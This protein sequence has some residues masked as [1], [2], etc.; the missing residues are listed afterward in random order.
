MRL[1]SLVLALAALSA[2]FAVDTRFWTFASKD[3]HDKATLNRLSLRSDGRITLAPASREL[4]DSGVSYLWAI[5]R[6]ADGTVYTG[7]G[8]P[9]AA[10]AR[11]FAV[12][13]GQTRVL[14]E[15]DGLQIQ[16]I[17]LDSAGRVYAATAPDGKIFRAGSNGKGELFYD[18][19]AKYI[20]SIAFDKS[21][22]LFVA[23]GDR[24]EIH[25]VTPQGQ[26]SVFFRTEEEHARSMVFDNAGNLIIGTEPSGLIMRV[27]PA[28]EGFVLHQA[29][30]REIT[31]L[32]VAPDGAIYAAAVGNKPNAP[33]APP[34]PAPAAAPAAAITVSA[35]GPGPASAPRA[36]APPPTLTPSSVSGGSEVIRIAADGFPTRVW[37]DTTE[38]VYAITFDKSGK[39]ILGSGNKGGIYR[40]DNDLQSTRLLSLSPTQVTA[41]VSDPSGAI[42]AATG[43]IGKLFQIGPG[44]EKDGVL[45]SE[46]LDASWFAEWGRLSHKTTG[47]V[48][49]ETRS[50]NLDRPQKNWSLW[51][52]GNGRIASPSGRFLQYRATLSSPDAS[53]TGTDIAYLAR[54]VAPR[55]ERIEI[56][57]PNYRFPVQTLSITPSSSLTLGGMTTRPS[58]GS[59]VP[60]ADPGAVTLTYAKGVQGARWMAS[61]ANGDN[62]QYDVEIRGKNESA[63]KPL[64]KRLTIRQ[65]SWDSSAFPDGEYLLR[66]TA[67]DASS[68]PPGK[69]L[70]DSLES[71]PFLIDNTPPVIRNLAASVS[72]NRVTITFTAADAATILTK[73]EYSINAAEWV[74]LEP[75]TRLTDSRE[76]NFSVTVDRPAGE[77]A[78]AVRVTD[79]FENHSVEKTIVK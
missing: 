23:T 48:N 6:G 45:E 7:G 72:G 11:I 66:V 31:A 60:S 43:N 70:T 42:Y 46:V 38:I 61:D 49:F 4:H 41:L 78:I 65:F 32:A 64:K 2:A 75:T 36:A 8:N 13:N 19:R 79:E 9:G 47:T 63:W 5:A 58:S 16:S 55:I 1:S 18:P 29:G 73:A 26:G 76:H 44:M 25:K 28:G 68:N 53:I 50:G 12:K 51:A 67:S 37:S 21:G 71:E 77:L 22:N 3:D 35:A 62:V 54:N 24:G 39:P 33:G 57:S 20:W 30:R 69:G 59:S 17:A 34:P 27:S 74:Y 40:I 52:P 14:A 15:L 56:T 10:T